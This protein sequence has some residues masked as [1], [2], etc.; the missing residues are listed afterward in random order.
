MR[1]GGLCYGTSNIVIQ[2]KLYLALPAIISLRSQTRITE[3]TSSCHRDHKSSGDSAIMTRMIQRGLK[4]V[5]TQE[6]SI[7]T[8]SY[9][10]EYN[11]F[12]IFYIV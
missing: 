7:N 12:N 9:N 5:M 2:F 8:G 1:L 6:D 10:T 11:L 3:I 4:I